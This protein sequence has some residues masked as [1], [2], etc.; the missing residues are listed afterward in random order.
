MAIIP[1]IKSI[2]T[3]FWVTN[4]QGNKRVREKS[5]TLF[6]IVI[7]TLLFFL[8]FI[9]IFISTK[10]SMNA[11]VTNVWA[12][13]LAPTKWRPAVNRN[14]EEHVVKCFLFLNFGEQVACSIPKKNVAQFAQV[15]EQFCFRNTICTSIEYNLFISW[16]PYKVNVSGILLFETKESDFKAMTLKIEG[17]KTWRMHVGSK[18]TLTKSYSTI[19]NH[20]IH[21]CFY[22]FCC[23]C[24]F[25][26]FVSN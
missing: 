10:N 17:I 9:I 14:L 19:R 22:L 1:A 13:V 15:K 23:C 26:F 25:V 21:I 2:K 4:C 8:F 3:C 6:L 24:F 5:E 16:H 11:L 18:N 7:I 20:F 12:V